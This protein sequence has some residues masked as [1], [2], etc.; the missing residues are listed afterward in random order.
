[1]SPHRR[2]SQT[3]DGATAVLPEENATI[4]DLQNGPWPCASPQGCVYNNGSNAEHIL[5]TKEDISAG[6]GKLSFCI[7]KI[8]VIFKFF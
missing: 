2:N 4:R 1:M 6:L 5:I 7:L 3:L 8:A